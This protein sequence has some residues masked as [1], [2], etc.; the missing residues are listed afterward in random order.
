MIFLTVGSMFPFDRLVRSVDEM[1]GQKLIDGMIV[2]Q[3]GDGRYEPKHMAF[4]RFLSKPEYDKRIGEATMLM[5]HAGVGTIALALKHRKPLLVVP[6]LKQYNEHVNDHQ[7]ATAR[8]FEELGHVLVAYDIQD[9]PAKLK[10]L[11]T[12][13]PRSREARPQDL[14]RRIGVFLE[15]LLPPG[16]TASVRAAA[17][18]PS[19]DRQAGLK[20]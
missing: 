8:K 1:L 3:I 15:T 16:S 2:A 6:R 13:S 5:G 17:C 4:D 10:A 20:R 19:N 9:I 7:V 18:T 14:A 12:F 11:R